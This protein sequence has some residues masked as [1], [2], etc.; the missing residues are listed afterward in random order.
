MR[1]LGIC[2]CMVVCVGCGSVSRVVV[3]APDGDSISM[4]LMDKQPS[5]RRY[6]LYILSPEGLSGSGGMSAFNEKTTWSVQLTPAERTRLERALKAAGWLT[7]SP[8]GEPDVDRSGTDRCLVISMRTSSQRMA[9]EIPAGDQGFGTDTSGILEMLR[10][11][12][13]RRFNDHVN[14][15][16]GAGDTIR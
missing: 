11:L 10:E 1:V 9:F 3:P 16:P 7:G 12:S 8:A 6:Q 15:L 13:A 2:L 14:G 4:G 5:Q